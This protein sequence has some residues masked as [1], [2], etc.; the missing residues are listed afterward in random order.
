MDVVYVG[1]H[2]LFIS[3]EANNTTPDMSTLR[4]VT[5]RRIPRVNTTLLP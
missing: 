5:D 1:F 3:T 2:I 4:V